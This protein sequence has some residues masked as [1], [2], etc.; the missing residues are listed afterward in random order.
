MDAD[1]KQHKEKR[2]AEHDAADDTIPPEV[3]KE[4]H[5]AKPKKEEEEDD[6]TLADLADFSK[7]YVYLLLV[8]A[9]AALVYYP[10]LDNEFVWDDHAFIAENEN[11]HSLGN[12]PSFFTHDVEGLYR[13]VRTVFYAL[14]YAIFG[15]H[16]FWYHLQALLIHV[17]ASVLV[18]YIILRLADS[19]FIAFAASL[20]FAVHPVHAEAIAFITASFD[21]I[22]IIFYLAAFLLYIK[23]SR[24]GKLVNMDQYYLAL[25]FFILAAFSS[26][27]ALTLPLVIVVYDWLFVEG[28]YKA[29][30]EKLRFYIPF[31]AALAGYLVI[32]FLFIGVI[33][34]AP[35]DTVSQYFL[36][37][38]TFTK[39]IVGY[40]YVLF[41]PKNL[42]IERTVPFAASI[43]ELAVLISIAVIAILLSIAYYFRHR[44]KLVTFSILF[45]FITLLPVS[46][47]IPIQ[48]F[49]AEAYLYLPMLGFALVASV[50]VHYLLKNIAEHRK[51]MAVLIIVLLMIPYS[52]GT[53]KRNE[54]WQDDMTLWK[55]AVIDSPYS[56][57]AHANYGLLLQQ[58]GQLKDAEQHYLQAIQLNP[59]REAVYFN[60]GT[61]YERTGRHELA[62]KAYNVSV[63]LNP[64]FADAHTN[65]GLVY[66]KLNQSELAL[67]H[68]IAAIELNPNNAVYHLNLGSFYNTMNESDLALQEF[69]LALKL[70]PKLAEAHYNMGIVYLKQK[71]YADAEYEMEQALALNQK[72]LQAK[73]VLDDLRKGAR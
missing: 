22:A 10:T 25:F 56:S 62:A 65:L 71:R 15:L 19:R 17:I 51:G 49:I 18:F 55:Q 20:I 63:S 40:L 14:S 6:I 1:K 46:N 54:V 57:K 12:I 70:N 58:A 73:I 28:H 9:T 11:I 21:Q 47:I 4:L 48:R 36:G 24:K 33:A 5:Q 59:Y 3:L 29:L 67:S 38:L 64:G 31:F 7:N 72:L 43:T 44:N 61:L 45:F 26:E 35:V 23:T 60:L 30:K 2:Q 34:R 16:P 53:V 32:R 52:I 66:G 41:Y 69:R 27:I 50:A 42:A 37:L 8:I 68:L 13:P 39:V